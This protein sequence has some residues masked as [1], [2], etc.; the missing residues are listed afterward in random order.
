MSEGIKFEGNEEIQK[1]LKEFEERSKKEE[2]KK[3]IKE[4]KALELPRMVQ[5]VIK[6]S[7]GLVKEQ[8]QAEY[9]LLGAVALMLALSL[10]FFF[11]GGTDDAAP[12]PRSLQD[13]D[14]SAITI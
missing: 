11:R 3:T 5:L 4:E 6:Y 13:S 7:G 1:A 10:Y 2:Q 9:V 14:G 12:V 8:K